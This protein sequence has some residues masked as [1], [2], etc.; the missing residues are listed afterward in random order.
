MVPGVLPGAQPEIDHLL[1]HVGGPRAERRHAVDHVHHQVVAVDVVQH[2]HVERCGGRALFLVTADVNVDVIRAPVRQAVDQPRIPVVGEDHRLVA[3]EDLVE[4]GILQTV[5]ML[6]G[7]LH[8]HQVDH[9]DH[10]HRE[11]WQV[12]PDQVR[13]CQRF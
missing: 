5:R 1:T 13:G 9:V 11:L 12:L 4:L 7:W 2:G 8:P 3:R 6:G 10:A